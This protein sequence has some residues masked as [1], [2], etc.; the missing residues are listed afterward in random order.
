MLYLVVL[1]RIPLNVAQSFASAQFVAVILAAA[2]VLSEP[3]DGFQWLGITC[4]AVGIVIV[5]WSH[6]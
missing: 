4:I 2:F 3:V 6:S 5:G 1:S